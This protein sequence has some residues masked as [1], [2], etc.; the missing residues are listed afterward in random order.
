MLT[1][2]INPA[3]CHASTSFINLQQKDIAMG[4]TP[5]STQIDITLHRKFMATLNAHEVYVRDAIRW[6]L[7][8]TQWPVEI[9]IEFFRGRGATGRYRV[10]LKIYDEDKDKITL[11]ARNCKKNAVINYLVDKATTA[12]VAGVLPQRKNDSHFRFTVLADKESWERLKSKYPARENN[13]GDWYGGVSHLCR[14]E[15]MSMPEMTEAGVN[16]LIDEWTKKTTGGAPSKITP[17]LRRRGLTKANIS[18]DG[19]AD[20]KVRR[21]AKGVYGGRGAIV[22]KALDNVVEREKLQS[23]KRAMTK[24]I[25]VAHQHAD[26]RTGAT[27][28][29]LQAR[30]DNIDNDRKKTHSSLKRLNEKVFSR[31][32]HGC[33]RWFIVWIIWMVVTTLVGLG[34]DQL[35][36]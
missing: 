34:I 17:E 11:L 27:L 32:E 23:E 18:L 29:A 13:D 1:A 6:A 31:R 36:K 14:A 20:A 25:G 3:L 30:I 7:R 4:I 21:L 35:L 22:W 24:T 19:A 2:K 12:C 33:R 15:I 16:E 10:C 26:D 8:N 9:P 5:L 28:L